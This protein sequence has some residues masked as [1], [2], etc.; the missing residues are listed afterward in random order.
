MRYRT[1]LLIPVLLISGAVAVARPGKHKR[2]PRDQQV[3]RTSAATPDVVLSVCLGSGSLSVQAWDRN[4]V[5]VSSSDGLPIELRRPT[6]ASNSGPARELTVVIG[7]MLSKSGSKCLPFGDIQIDVPRE[8]NLQLQTRDANVSVS[9]GAG[10]YVVT[11]GGS[12]NVQRVT[13]LVAV[14]SIGGNISVQ[15]SKA[16]IKLHS[17]G[18]SIDVHGVAPNAAGDVCE[19]GTIGADITLA[20][21]SHGQVIVSTVSGDVSFSS[22]LTHGGRYSFQTIQGDVSLSLPAD[23]SFRLNANL[24]SGGDVNSDFPL[25]SSSSVEQSDPSSRRGSGFHHLEAVYGT[26]D[27]LINLSSFGGAVRLR[28]K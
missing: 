12:V 20:Q 5:R 26:G 23:S 19:A 16:S 13:R 7:N 27:A 24:G 15:D 14:S 18:G 4:Q 17:V 2:A 1:L 3:E 8:A 9:G 11:Q 6:G 10:V 22:S 28:K 21:I 25:R